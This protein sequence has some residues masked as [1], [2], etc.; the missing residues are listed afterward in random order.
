[1]VEQEQFNGLT[2]EQAARLQQMK[3]S[4]VPETAVVKHHVEKAVVPKPVEAMAPCE[5]K[6]GELTFY[7]TSKGYGFGRLEDGEVV[8][9]HRK[10][11]PQGDR[12]GPIPKGETLF[13]QLSEGGSGKLTEARAVRRELP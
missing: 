1:M 2:E 12:N 11:F 4:M 10:T 6:K 8:F 3:A 5:W 9:F 13:F 7:K